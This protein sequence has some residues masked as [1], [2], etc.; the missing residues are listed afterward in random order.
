MFR[1]PGRQ[2][3]VEGLMEKAPF[4]RF[5]LQ[6]ICHVAPSPAWH[7]VSRVA[8]GSHGPCDGTRTLTLAPMQG[9]EQTGVKCGFEDHE[10]YIYIFFLSL[11]F[12]V[13]SV[14]T[15]SSGRYHRG[16][17]VPSPLSRALRTSLAPRAHALRWHLVI[18]GSLKQINSKTWG[19]T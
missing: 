1:H 16:H 15:Q 18:S 10:F 19:F 4:A 14:S 3:V 13:F 5:D 8:W 7:R 2:K 11:E 9:G 17:R 12:R 6:N